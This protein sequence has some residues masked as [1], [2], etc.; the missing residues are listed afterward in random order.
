MGDKFYKNYAWD[1]I[2]SFDEVFDSQDEPFPGMQTISKHILIKN[3]NKNFKVILEAQGG[4]DIA[5]F[6]KYVFP[7]YI[8]S[9][10]NKF[11]FFRAFSEI[12]KFNS[13]ENMKVIQF[14]KFYKDC[15]KNL[16]L[17]NL[18]ADGTSSF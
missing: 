14:S 7:F 18:S 16:E 3:Y 13:I 1:I 12:I 6:Y 2:N 15:I 10:S 4:D 17:G 5:A 11:K 9:L 8:K